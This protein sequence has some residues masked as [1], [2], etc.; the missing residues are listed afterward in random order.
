MSY[1][2][3][4]KSHIPFRR[5]YKLI[6]ILEICQQQGAHSRNSENYDNI[7]YAVFSW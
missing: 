1:Y 5:G 7:Y 3:N 6:K 4:L 2:K